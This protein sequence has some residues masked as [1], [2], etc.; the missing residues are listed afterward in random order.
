MQTHIPVEANEFERNIITECGKFSMTGSIRMWALIQSMKHIRHNK[1]N[2]DFVECG[3]WKGGNLALMRRFCDYHKIEKCIFGYDTFDGMSEPTLEDVDLHGVYAS[4]AMRKSPK[5][6]AITNIHAYAGLQQVEENLRTLNSF[7]GVRLIKG[8]VEESLVIPE[9]LP[10]QISILRLDTDWYESTKI[11]LDVLFPRLV[12]GGI[13][14]I[15][16]YGHFKGAQKAVDDYFR[17]QNIWLHYIDYTCRLMI[18][19]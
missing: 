13:L 10:Q 17:N 6:E 11:E 8:K 4:D 12:K 7:E 9:N 15:D 5:N 19:E 3:V 1:I 16:D 14:I 18:K 2:G